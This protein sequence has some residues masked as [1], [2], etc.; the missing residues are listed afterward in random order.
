MVDIYAPMLKS[1]T[2]KTA[3]PLTLAGLTVLAGSFLVG[4]FVFSASGAPI[5]EGA[6]VKVSTEG[7]HGS[8]VHIDGLVLTA[9]HVIKDAKIVQVD[10]T[11]AE[12]LWSNE[13]YDVAMLKPEAGGPDAKLRCT[14][15]VIGEPLTAYGY[16]GQLGYTQTNGKVAG[17]TGKLGEWKAAFA[18]DL[19]VYMGNSGGPA[20]DS[21]G[22]VAA[23]VVGWLPGT[24][25]SILVPGSEVCRMLGR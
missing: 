8:G 23:M 2:M 18:A 16:P 7:G 1:V 19:T 24:G 14:P 15:P 22:R 17:R 9:A 21:R 12:V 11:A 13:A 25:F 5:T 3:I 6:V 4:T 20:F 10:D